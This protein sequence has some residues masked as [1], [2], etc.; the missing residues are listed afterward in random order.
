MIKI[1][2]ASAG[3][4]KTYA[5]AKSYL[6]LLTERYAYRHILAVTFT[7][8]A[9][10]EMKSRILR[11]LSEDGGQQSQDMLRDILHDYS[12]FSVTTIDKFFQQALKAF[13]REI[14]QSADYQIDLDKEA[15]TAEAMDRILDSLTAESID[16]LGWLRKSVSDSLEHNRRVNIERSLYET[17][18]LLMKEEAGSREERKAQF[19]KENVGAVL[20]NCNDII[21]AFTS[22]IYAAAKELH[23]VKDNSIKQLAKFFEDC[24]TWK[25]IK[26][27]GAT[28]LKEAAGTSFCDLLE[29]DEYRWYCTAWTIRDGSFSLALAGEFYRSFE[30]LLR[31]KNIMVLD[32]SNT[33]LKDIIAGSDAPFVY[34]KMGVRYEHFLLDEFQDTSTIQ[35][36]N[37]RPLLRESDSAGHDDLIVGDVKQSIYRWRNSD[38][39]LLAKQVG[40]DFPRARTDTLENNWRSCRTIVEFNNAFF[41][42]AAQTVGRSDLYADVEQKVKSD[43]AQP[44][45]VRV[46][47]CDGKD[48]TAMVCDSVRDA[49]AAGAGYGD[50]A[51]V[52]RARKEGKEIADALIDAGIPVISDDSLTIKSSLIVRKLTGILAFYENPDDAISRFISEADNIEFPSEYHSLVDL[53]ENLLRQLEASNPDVFAGETLFIQAFMDNLREWVDV[54]GNE[55]RYFLEHWLDSDPTISSPSSNAAVRVLTIHKS[56][57]LEFPYLIFPFAEKVTMYQKEW[58]WCRL[59]TEGTPFIPEAAGLYPVN[60]NDNVDNTLFSGAKDAE[61][62]MQK[63]DNLNI[64]YVALTR[65]A[66]CLHVIAANP[67]ASFKKEKTPEYKNF[68]QILYDFC[69]RLDDSCRGQ[70]YNFATAAAGAASALLRNPIRENAPS[71]PAAAEAT[72]NEIPF[73]YISIPIGDRLKTSSEAGDF[74][75]ED[76]SVGAAASPR[77]NGIALHGILS[78][79]QT[80]GDLQ[81]AVDAAVMNGVLNPTEGDEAL[82]LLSSRIAS[83]PEW[84]EGHS[85]N[86]TTVF[87]S[88]GTEHRP[89]RVV[90]RDGNVTVIDYKFGESSTDSDAKYS[91][92]VSRYMKVFRSLGFKNVS[93]VI[94]YVVPDKLITL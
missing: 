20:A 17:G 88:N 12:A 79:V 11:F 77:R 19:S 90:I 33:I 86:E 51:V 62:E 24:K 14:G 49:V 6:A 25:K 46:S 56:K 91:R 66:K 57:G 83:H 81:E 1:L 63:V 39:T 59:E 65:A 82:E 29:G 4:G 92:Q 89:D 30:E 73:S 21:N 44:G 37:F 9:T 68:S 28:L 2:K 13:A 16:I 78:S 80:A 87:D 53:C 7:N 94:W 38:W 84:F 23:V 34:E 40:E 72:E 55:L 42:F 60:L 85:L 48:E 93:G 31:E 47:F 54:N 64:F 3:S 76:G 8:K 69:G 75:G 50:I 74:F 32:E 58:H 27:P 35:W 45:F 15:L 52:V 10:A 18:E 67:P 36:E 5:L 71:A 41:K 26:L 43:D 22:K 70:M 61:A